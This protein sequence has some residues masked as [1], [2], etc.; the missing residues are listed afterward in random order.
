MSNKPKKSSVRHT[1]AVQRD[2]SKRPTVSAPDEVIEARL[3]ELIHPATYAQVATFQ[4]MG[5][6]ERVLTLPVMMAFV[7]SLIWRHVGAVSEAVRVLNQEGLLWTQP[8]RVSAPAVTQRLSSLPAVL[9][10]NVLKA[11]LPMMRQQWA[12]RTRGIPPAVTWAQQQF[13]R[14]L[15]LDGSTLDGLLRKV[16]LLRAGE[17]TPL[18]GR[19]AAVLDLVTRVPDHVW[20]EEDAQA[21]DQRFW[22]RVLASLVKHSLLIFDS[23][24]LNFDLFDQMTTDQLWFITRPKSNTVY[25]VQS[26]L[27]HSAQV[28]DRVIALGSAQ[29]RCAHAMR[30]VEV[31]WHGKWYRYLTNVLDAQRLPAEVILALYAQ[32]WRIEDAFNTIKRL[33]GLAYFWVG[34]LNGIL[35]QIWSTWVLYAV[36]VDFTDEVAQALH[37]PFQALSLEMVFR[38]LYHFTQAYHR[39]EA[40]DPIAYLVHHAKLLGIIKRKRKTRSPAELLHLTIPKLA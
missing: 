15:I 31:L 17:G 28:H 30:L 25:Q 22:G 11:L 26:V 4:A 34:S 33:L 14:V 8:T 10:E 29:H 6:R 39:G 7:V 36:L 1:R 35:V 40:T 23:G 13:S 5:L 32:R 24:F 2:Q 20:F 27:R 19:I 38:G 16:G 3:T 37:L 12:T 18:A 21:H 9:F